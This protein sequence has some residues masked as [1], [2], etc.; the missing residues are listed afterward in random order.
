MTESIASLRGQSRRRLECPQPRPVTDLGRLSARLNTPIRAA[1]G[2][3]AKNQGADLPSKNAIETPPGSEVS[4]DDCNGGGGQRGAA[5]RDRGSA[6]DRRRDPLGP[7]Q[8]QEHRLHR[9]IPDR[10]R[11][12]SPRGAGRRR[13]SRA[14]SSQRSMRSVSATITSCTTGGHRPDP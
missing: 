11:H 5:S 4:G 1:H 3:T 10:D 12:R 14:R 9:R 6:G 13:M 7:H 2:E 8:G